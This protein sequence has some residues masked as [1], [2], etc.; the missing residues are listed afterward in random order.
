MGGLWVHNA[1]HE[2]DAWWS[3]VNV[4]MALK[5]HKMWAILS[6]WENISFSRRTL[7]HELLI[8][9]S[10][11]NL[12]DQFITVRWVSA[13]CV[14]I[15]T[16]QLFTIFHNT[17]YLRYFLFYWIVISYH[18]IKRVIITVNTELF[19]W[20]TV[21]IWVQQQYQKHRTHCTCKCT[22]VKEAT[23]TNDSGKCILHYQCSTETTVE[24]FKWDK[25]LSR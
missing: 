10:A 12:K 21:L 11:Y 15:W 17:T 4:D 2:W 13:F 16:H 9:L 14:S 5:F 23:T 25:Q 18:Y 7:L 3:A 24:T 8:L 20:G 1:I 6:T 22:T 19:D